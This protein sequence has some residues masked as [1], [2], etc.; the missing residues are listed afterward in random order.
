MNPSSDS[1]LILPERLQ[2]TKTR[3]REILYG[4]DLYRYK[5]RVAKLQGLT[6]EASLP[7]LK[8]GEDRKSVV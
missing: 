8:I 4:A 1:P 7:R 2:A 5:G 6:V 3:I